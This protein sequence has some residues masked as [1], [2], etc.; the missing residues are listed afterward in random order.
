M[1]HAG[2]GETVAPLRPSWVASSGTT[3]NALLR[4]GGTDIWVVKA[5]AF[6]AI[7][8]EITH[9]G[10]SND[11]AMSIIPIGR[12]KFI[13]ACNSNSPIAKSKDRKTDH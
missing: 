3:A 6:G 11:E 10:I 8:W 4:I 7:D 13:V 1:Q 5:N 12:G 2:L 9:G